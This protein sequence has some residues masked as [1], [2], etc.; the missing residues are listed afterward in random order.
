MPIATTGVFNFCS[1]LTGFQC[2]AF[3]ETENHKP[4]GKIHTLIKNWRCI[5]TICEYKI[6][7]TW[8]LYNKQK[9]F[10]NDFTHTCW[11]NIFSYLL[12]SDTYFVEI[13][14]SLHEIKSNK[15]YKVYF[16]KCNFL[17]KKVK[18]KLEQA[19]KVQRGRRGR[20][21]LLL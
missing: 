9:D 21:V 11:K 1:Q 19:M 2:T 18:S 20:T 8:N 16:L 15:F 7:R 6:C 13:E 10:I 5:K 12:S 3:S 17:K 14:I 4:L